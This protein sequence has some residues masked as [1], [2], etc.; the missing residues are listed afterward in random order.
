MY[1]QEL[2]YAFQLHHDHC[3]KQK[4]LN[5]STRNYPNHNSLIYVTR[6][7]KTYLLGT[8]NFFERT[9]IKRFKNIFQIIFLHIWI[10]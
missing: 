3:V 7:W 2:H 5:M 1:I 9:Q 4:F 10:T 8:S 6:S